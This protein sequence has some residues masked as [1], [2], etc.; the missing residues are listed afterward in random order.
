MK[1]IYFDTNTIDRAED[2]WT[3]GEFESLLSSQGFIPSISIHNM[4]EL[5]KGFLEDEKEG[6]IRCLFRFLDQLENPHLVPPTQDL[7]RAEIDKVQGRGIQLLIMHEENRRR[8]REEIWR[9]AYGSTDDAK[10]FIQKRESKIIREVPLVAQEIIRRV[11]ELGMANPEYY[12]IP[13]SF[14]EFKDSLK[15]E[16]KLGTLR[17]GLGNMGIEFLELDLQ[18]ILINSEDY[19]VINTWLNSNFYLHWIPAKYKKSP[20]LD[21]FSDFR[22]VVNCC[23]VDI[24]VSDDKKLIDRFS[25]L[26]PFRECL[27]WDLFKSGL[28]GENPTGVLANQ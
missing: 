21:K 18:R 25:D 15:L 8:M 9:M 4:Y 1:K 10:R 2:S 13:G 11:D 5:A 26:N 12:K 23:A 14:V 3:A 17:M 6:R 27:S 22:H 7:I 20:S 24:L 28:E 19:P 16:D